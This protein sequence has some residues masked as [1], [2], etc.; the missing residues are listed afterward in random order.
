MCNA[1]IDDEE[2]I[3]FSRTYRAGGT[4]LTWFPTADSDLAR[5]QK[6]TY[7][8]PCEPSIRPAALVVCGGKRICT[9]D[10]TPARR[11]R[12]DA[13]FIYAI[14]G[15]RAARCL[16]PWRTNADSVRPS[17]GDIPAARYLISLIMLSRAD[18]DPARRTPTSG[19]CFDASTDGAAMSTYQNKSPR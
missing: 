11:P 7:S 18:P 15:L 12:R 4:L 17:V 14:F 13:I 3:T 19:T 9:L 8:I 10:S 16:Y 6:G 1:R 5:I 2:A